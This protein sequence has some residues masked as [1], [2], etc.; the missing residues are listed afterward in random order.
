[1]L[2]RALERSL[3]GSFEILE[4][5]EFPN[6]TYLE[7]ESPTL[8]WRHYGFLSEILSVES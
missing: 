5:F 7:T 3:F 6:L 8:S 4:S 1:V 2:A